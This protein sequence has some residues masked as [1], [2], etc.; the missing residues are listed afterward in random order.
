MKQVALLGCTSRILRQEGG[1]G[2]KVSKCLEKIVHRPL[3]YRN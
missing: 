2:V 3:H 1:S